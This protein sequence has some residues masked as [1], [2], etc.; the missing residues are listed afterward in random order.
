MSQILNREIKMHVIIVE[1]EDGRTKYFGPIDE[2]K[3]FFDFLENCFAYEN[4]PFTVS[5]TTLLEPSEKEFLK[6][7][8]ES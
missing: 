2:P 6:F 3:K 8:K 1:H 7:R 4:T 5:M